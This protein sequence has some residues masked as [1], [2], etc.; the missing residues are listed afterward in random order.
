MRVYVA[1]SWRNAIQPGVVRRLRA[2]G[3]EVYDFRNPV[4][5][6]SGFSW[7]EIDPRWKDWT[8]EEYIAAMSHPAAERGFRLDMDALKSCDAC[9]LV[10]PCGVSAALE[11]GW[12]V[13]AGRLGLVLVPGIREPDLMF[14][15]GAGLCLSIDDVVAKLHEHML[16]ER[17]K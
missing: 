8:S 11:F 16:T 15:M 13:G 1:S 17:A 5:G 6:D 4:E 10:Q 2:E 14:K 7:S 12:A 3:H 9:V